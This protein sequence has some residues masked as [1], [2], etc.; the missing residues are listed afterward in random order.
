MNTLFKLG[1]INVEVRKFRDVYAQIL[2]YILQSMITVDAGRYIHTQ[3]S[4]DTRHFRFI[5]LRGKRVDMDVAN[6]VLE[7]QFY[8][9]V[10]LSPSF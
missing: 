4:A 8:Y 10:L 1:Q 7:F 3:M 2:D 9:C 5:V 6:Y